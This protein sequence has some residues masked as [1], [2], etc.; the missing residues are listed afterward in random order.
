VRLGAACSPAVVNEES[1][2]NSTPSEPA[3]LANPGD[4]PHPSPMSSHAK[5]QRLS[6]RPERVSY[7]LSR[8]SPSKIGQVTTASAEVWTA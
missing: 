6:H 4:A 1:C 7:C 5:V 8:K 3:L 2:A